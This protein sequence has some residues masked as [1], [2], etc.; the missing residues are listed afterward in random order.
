MLWAFKVLCE[1]MLDNSMKRS[2]ALDLLKWKIVHQ[3]PR[4][5]VYSQ[6]WKQH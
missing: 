5:N 1:K 6:T 3:A 4:I 2:D